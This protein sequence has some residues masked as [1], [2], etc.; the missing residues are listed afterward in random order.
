ME[1]E[2]PLLAS[3][4]VRDALSRMI[5]LP[6]GLEIVLHHRLQYSAHKTPVHFTS[7]PR[8]S[9]KTDYIDPIQRTG[10]VRPEPVLSVLK[11]DTFHLRTGRSDR[12][13]LTNGKWPK[14]LSPKGH[15]I[16]NELLFL[17]LAFDR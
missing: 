3:K 9:V 16:I 10:P 8:R 5:S 15:A 11:T 7:S 12:T 13:A 17:S 4:R 1:S 6:K 2:S 14:F